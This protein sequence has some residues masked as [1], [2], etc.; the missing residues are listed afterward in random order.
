MNL[1]VK[2]RPSKNCLNNVMERDG[3]GG[4]KYTRRGGDEQKKRPPIKEVQKKKT[5]TLTEEEK[6]VD[7]GGPVLDWWR[8]LGGTKGDRWGGGRKVRSQEEKP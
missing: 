8:E 7:M 5:E 2:K 1:W 4:S 3:R 6:A